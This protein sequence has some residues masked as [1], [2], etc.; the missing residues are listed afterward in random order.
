V[1]NEI[2]SALITTFDVDGLMDVL[3][4]ELPR[5]G[6]PGCYVSLYENPRQP[7]GQARLV[8]AYDERGRLESQV[9]DCRFAAPLLIPSEILPQ[10]RRYS[11]V[12]EAL[13]F[14]EEQLGF[15]LFEESPH[16]GTIYYML[17]EQLSS[18]LKGALLMHQ[19]EEQTMKA[20]KARES[21][22]KANQAKSVFLASMSHELRTPLNAILGYADILKRRAGTTGPFTD[23]L[24]IIQRSGEHLLT[25][26]NDVLDLAKVEAG[27][28][29]L[30]PAPF[31]LPTFLRQIVDIVRARAEAKDLTLTYEALSPLPA[32]IVADET[33]LRQVLLN[34]LGNAVK[35]TDRGEVVLSVGVG[36]YGSGGVGEYGSMG[37]K[38]PHTPTPPH[39]LTSTLRFS[40]RDT[41]P[42]IPTDQLARLFQPFEQGGAAGKRAEGTGLGLAIS[43]QIVQLMGNRVQVKSPAF[44]SPPLE[45]TAGGPGSLFWFEVALPGIESFAGEPP[46][47]ILLRRI[48]G[49]EGA[50]RKVL[51]VDDRRYNRLLLVDMLEPLGFEVSTAG[52]GQEAVDKAL[53]WRPDAIIM[54]LVMPVKTGFEAAQEIRQ[55]PELKEVFIVAASA[56]VLEADQERSR[57]AGCN[58]FLPK[59]IHA[60][61]LLAAL[62][63]PLNL[64][65]LYAEAEAKSEAPLLPPPMEELAL[66]S[67][68]ADEGR[69]LNIRAEATRLEELDEAY[70]PFA[71]RL[72]ELA[73]GFE[74]DQIKAFVKQSMEE[75]E[76]E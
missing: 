50:R 46:T 68:L 57:V 55:Q 69:I 58:V 42:G 75:K 15:A 9:A 8:L 60:D 61:D 32:T 36:E 1:L 72:Q 71:R 48:T 54:D 76:G 40:V 49:Y 11:Y 18:A 73:K 4:Q 16:R 39:P 35:F 51:V 30:A 22:E 62:T 12:V 6:I 67:R 10:E 31:H 3:A 17:R 43:Q 7:A 59:P 24:D 28:L 5:L 66:L 63:A 53:A 29:E 44:T 21:A 70:V 23:G 37:V 25:L 47:P 52:D 13:Y 56:S 26:I 45:G 65:W 19:L 74:I 33:R 41:G 27:K 14:R 64:T 20:E 34:L 38:P 2:G